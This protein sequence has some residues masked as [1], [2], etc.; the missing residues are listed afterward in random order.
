VDTSP[1]TVSIQVATFEGARALA[2]VTFHNRSEHEIWILRD[3]P[4]LFLECEGARIADIGPAVKR[5]PYTLADYERVE[6]GRVVHRQQEISDKFAWLPGAHCY[7]VAIGGG[8]V[9]PVSHA[10]FEA[11]LVKASFELRR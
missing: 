1:V 10:R 4:N 3:P 6:P 7:E 2:T 9:D 8:Y 11:P 5:R